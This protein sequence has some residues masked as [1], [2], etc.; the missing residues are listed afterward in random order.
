MLSRTQNLN[1]DLNIESTKRSTKVYKAHSVYRKK[2]L[3]EIN[4]EFDQTDYLLLLGD[5]S[6][7]IK[8]ITQYSPRRIPP[9]SKLR[10]QFP[11]TNA[12]LKDLSQDEIDDLKVRDPRRPFVPYSA[13]PSKFN[14]MSATATT[15]SEFVRRY[16][17]WRTRKIPYGI[18]LQNQTPGSSRKNS[19]MSP[20][21]R[22]PKARIQ[23]RI[24]IED[25]DYDSD[26]ENV[27]K[28]IQKNLQFPDKVTDED[29]YEH[30]SNSNQNEE[31][32]NENQNEEENQL[33]TEEDLNENEG[34]NNF[35]EEE[36]NENVNDNQINGDDVVNDQDNGQDVIEEEES[37]DSIN[38]EQILQLIQ[39]DGNEIN[40]REI[41]LDEKEDD[42]EQNDGDIHAQIHYPS[43]FGFNSLGIDAFTL[44]QEALTDSSDDGDERPSNCGCSQ[45]G[46]GYAELVLEINLND[47][48]PVI[49][50]LYKG[51]HTLLTVPKTEF[52][53]LKSKGFDWIL[54]E[55]LHK[56]DSKQVFGETIEDYKQFQSILHQSRLLF[57]ADY[58]NDEF[59]QYLDGIRVNT[60]EDFQRLRTLYPNKTLITTFESQQA[61]YYY[62]DR[63]I[64]ALR[65]KND[66]EIAQSI[67]NVKEET[68]RHMA[69]V[70]SPVS[71][72]FDKRSARTAAAMLLTLP[73]MR[74]VNFRELGLV[75]LVLIVLSKKA[76]RKGVFSLVQATSNT[77][78]LVAW[79]YTRG[80]QR[81]LI[82]ANFGLQ[83]TT[84]DIICEDAAGTTK[85]DMTDILTQT[86]YKRDP[87][88][89]REKGLTV[90]LY[91]Y[92]IQIFEY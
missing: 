46:N 10:K 9:Y 69:H 90:I 61:Q 78:N 83:Q 79:K 81:I 11:K 72:T 38:E 20:N 15:D 37:S 31:E 57:A 89:L 36:T 8:A 29:S 42:D 12:N 49:N 76:V 43:G 84:G 23:D 39:Q 66:R 45:N 7:G 58:V 28:S 19:T 71:L 75:D 26:E 48:I 63:I 27:L 14:T 88:E 32:L 22:S 65:E 82:A 51:H 59:S 85:I 47:F 44:Q 70:F 68:R 91:Q 30:N 24:I 3:K 13:T 1:K 55:N 92:E 52:D 56:P 62:D 67:Y 54:I 60:N 34:E 40:S 6:A 80:K 17:I 2:F 18:T 16:E 35:E 33:F 25:E 77:G 86:I 50:K 41:Q 73:G 53:S 74:I 5:E 64:N 87:K 21:Y 4:G